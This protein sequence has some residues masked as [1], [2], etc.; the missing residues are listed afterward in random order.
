MD[1]SNFLNS[2]EAFLK[3]FNSFVLMLDKEFD[4][5]DNMNPAYKK[6]YFNKLKDLVT[7]L[8]YLRGDNGVFAFIPRSANI[9]YFY[10]IE[11]DYRPFFK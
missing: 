5:F 3:F 4:N 7:V 9:D 11:N 6:E 8:S 1:E 10:K 2:Q